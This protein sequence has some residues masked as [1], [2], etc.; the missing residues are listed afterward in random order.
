MRCT[1]CFNFDCHQ[2]SA[3]LLRIKRRIGSLS[4]IRESRVDDSV[5][6]PH[7]FTIAL[8]ARG[9]TWAFPQVWTRGFNCTRDRLRWARVWRF[10]LSFRWPQTNF[11]SS[12]LFVFRV[13]KS[14]CRGTRSSWNT[15][16]NSPSY[17]SKFTYFYIIIKAD[18]NN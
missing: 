9:K 1:Q 3:L 16:R 17:I 13:N 6:F 14:V 7:D 5:T 12:L 4:V 11:A 8:S 2:I 15:R 10:D 18:L